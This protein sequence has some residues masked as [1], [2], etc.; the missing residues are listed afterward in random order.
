MRRHRKL[1]GK[2]ISFQNLLKAAKLAQRNK[3]FKNSTALF[4][5]KC[6]A[7]SA[8]GRQSTSR[9]N[10]WS[11]F[12]YLKY[13]CFPHQVDHRH[14]PTRCRRLC[15]PRRPDP[16]L[17]RLPRRNRHQLRREAG[18]HRPDCDYGRN[19]KRAP[20]GR[21]A[22]PWHPHHHRHRRASCAGR[23]AHVRHADA[24]H[25]L[26][27]SADGGHDHD[28]HQLGRLCGRL[29]HRDRE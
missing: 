5:F 15:H 9:W 3:R 6:P 14:A 29:L 20:R 28:H 8:G 19:W 16:H 4:N 25:N 10:R 21:H 2:I 22:E 1:Y 11:R 23:M 24:L 13:R 7:G 27:H 26:G 12:R 18:G 17:P